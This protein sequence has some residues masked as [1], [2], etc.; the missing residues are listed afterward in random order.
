MNIKSSEMF[1]FEQELFANTRTYMQ[2]E[3]I[4]FP[5]CFLF[6]SVSDVSACR[7]HAL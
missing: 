2:L 6:S 4:F 5:L 7:P 1:T 3:L